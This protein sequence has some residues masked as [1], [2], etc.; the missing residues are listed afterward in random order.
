MV[1]EGTATSRLRSLVVSGLIN[2]PL[3]S[4]PQ[5]LCIGNDHGFNKVSATDQA[6]FTEVGKRISGTI[7]QVSTVTSGDTYQWEGTLLVSGFTGI[8][9]IGLISSL[10][11]PIQDT[12]AQQISSRTQSFIVPSHFNLWPSPSGNFY[13]IQV[14]TE[15]MTITGTN[16]TNTL[17]VQ[18]GINNSTPLELI[19]VGTTITQVSGTLFQHISSNFPNFSNGDTIQF[20]IQEIFE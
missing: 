2:Q 8:T 18:R 7:T 16:G 9:N 11:S 1:V 13:N 5:F 10:G 19:S 4:G 3:Y 14:N 12:L 15:V 20:I 6:L 17:Y